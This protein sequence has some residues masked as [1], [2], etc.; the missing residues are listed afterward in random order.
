LS[1][2]VHVLYMVKNKQP[3]SFDFA[4][5]RAQVLA[6]FRNQAIDRLK[7]GEEAFLRRRANV[8]IADDF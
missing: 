5:A 3:V 4:K 2:G 6:D 7:S 1:D 8:R